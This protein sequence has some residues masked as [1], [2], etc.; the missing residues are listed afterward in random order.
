MGKHIDI[1]GL[2]AYK[3]QSDSIYVAKEEGKGLIKTTDVTK[4]EGI[5]E[6]AQKNN[7]TKVTVNGTDQ[8]IADGTLTIDVEAVIEGDG[9]VKDEE[10]TT[11]LGDYVKTETADS[12]YVKT[13]ELDAKVKTA[14]GTVYH[15]KGSKASLT[16][17]KAVEAPQE[18]DVYNAEDTGAN[19]VYV[20]EG[21]GDDESGWDKLS[22]TVDLSSYA[23]TDS[24]TTGLAAKADTTALDNYVKTETLTTKLGDYVTS[25]S[26]TSQLEGKVDDTEL[27]GYVKTEAIVFATEEDIKKEVFGIEQGQV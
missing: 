6:G 12:T 24:L 11:T 14:V 22:E 17:I 15:P 4:L 7:I 8:T 1:D 9:F 21:Q 13:A 18:G 16:E 25:E 10:L 2:K 3:K 20:G 23:T 27:E 5:E 19:Y 26:L